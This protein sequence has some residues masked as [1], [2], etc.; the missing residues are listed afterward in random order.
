[1]LSRKDV[2]FRKGVGVRGNVAVI[3]RRRQNT[4]RAGRKGIP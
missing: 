3:P 1:M 4:V 2:A